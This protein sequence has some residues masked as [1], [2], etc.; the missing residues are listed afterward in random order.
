MSRMN[1]KKVLTG[2]LSVGFFLTGV[3]SGAE[4]PVVYEADVVHSSISFTIR[5]M[6]VSKVRGHFNDFKVVVTGDD[7]DLTKSSVNAVIMVKSIDT[8]NEKRDEHLRGADFFAVEQFP[9]IRFKSIK[10]KPTESGFDIWGEFSM[11]GV[12][13]NMILPF[14]IL[15]RMTDGQGLRRIGVEALT[16]LDRKDYGLT[17]NRTLDKGGLALGNEVEVE[18]LLELVE[19]K[20]R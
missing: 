6:V 9:E 19:K 15:G 20:A 4:A 14:K 10:V 5:H 1:I 13:K 7:Q 11:H 8:G 17:Y 16:T 18:I 12:T 2:L 3:L